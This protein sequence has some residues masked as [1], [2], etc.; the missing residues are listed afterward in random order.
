MFTQ[1]VL[2]ITGEPGSGKS[3]VLQVFKSLGATVVMADQ[4]IAE[5]HEETTVR[6]AIQQRFFSDRTDTDYTLEEVRALVNSDD[7]VL[8]L[9][10]EILHPPFFRALESLI[11]KFRE[12]KKTALLCIEI[13]LLYETQS[14]R[15][16]N[17][18]LLTHCEAEVQAARL[19]DRGW[20]ESR[21]SRMKK[22]LDP[23]EE[24]MEKSTFQVDT[25]RSWDE[26]E[27]QVIAIYQHI[28]GLLCAKSS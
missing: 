20:P 13:P 11:S 9:L 6:Q 5:L 3:T 26:T 12:K 23:L 8:P 10:E 18:I 16:C 22:R 7:Q 17:G 19:K 4:I 21:W 27:Q 2:G 24:K 15:Y 25:S 1:Y 28:Q 14:E